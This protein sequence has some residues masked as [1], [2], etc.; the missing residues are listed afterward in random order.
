MAVNHRVR[1]ELACGQ[2]FI[3]PPGS[4]LYL[5][6]TSSALRKHAYVCSEVMKG[7]E[8]FR[9]QAEAVFHC[10]DITEG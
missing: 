1:I 5:K 10:L 6:V 4:Q 8:V 3:V 2:R 7:G 9:L